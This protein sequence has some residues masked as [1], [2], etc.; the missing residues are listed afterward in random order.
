MAQKPNPDDPRVWLYLG[1]EL[2]GIFIKYAK[3]DTR[4]DSMSDCGRHL[5][6]LG[7]SADKKDRKE[8]LKDAV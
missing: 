8:A 7:M 1:K 6:L 5:I 3:S 4:F 2:K